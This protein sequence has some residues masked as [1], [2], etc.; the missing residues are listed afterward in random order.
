MKGQ[1]GQRCVVPGPYPAVS[2]AAARQRAREIVAAAKRGEDLAEDE[3]KRAAV[4]AATR[5]DTVANVAEEFVRR[6]LEGRDRATSY[7]N[8]SNVRR[9]YASPLARS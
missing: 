2:L 9:T 8:P 4:A 3:R 6:S 1:P 5:S 7:G